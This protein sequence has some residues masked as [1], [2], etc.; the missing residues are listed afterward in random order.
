MKLSMSLVEYW[1]KPYNPVSILRDD[2]RTIASARMFSYDKVINSDYLY[3]GRNKDFFE[4]STS[5]EVLLVHKNSVIST[6]SRDLEEIF[7]AVL[8]A[9]T[10]FQEW[11]QNMLEAFHAA[12]P[13]AHIIDQ[14]KEFFGPIFYATSSLQVT[15]FSPEY[16]KGSVNQ[17]WDDFWDYGTFSTDSFHV[18]KH[19]PFMKR[20]S[21]VWECEVF[22]ERT[23]GENYPW[24]LMI[25]QLNSANVLCGQMVIISDKM[26]QPWQMHLAKYIHTILCMVAGVGRQQGTESLSLANSMFT[27]F[28]MGKN[29]TAMNLQTLSQ[30]QGYKEK[31]L[32][33]ICFVWQE[34]GLKAAGPYYEK[35]IRERFSQ[36]LICSSQD[37]PLNKEMKAPDGFLVC[38][39]L[40]QFSL[41]RKE[42]RI[43]ADHYPYC[44]SARAFLQFFEQMQLSY[45]CSFP[46]EGLRQ[47][48]VQY[49]QA[50]AAWKYGASDYYGCGL[51]ELLDLNGSREQRSYAVNPIIARM[52]E[53]DSLYNSDFYKILKS[54]LRNERNRVKTAEELYVHK[55]TLVYRLEKMEQIFGLNLEDSYEREYL[56]AS[57]RTLEG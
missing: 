56:L 30:I 7:N 16:G 1:L 43:S 48:P 54:Y 18:M 19:S 53:Y 6:N 26:F 40:P 34:N 39:P 9:F 32:F 55:N 11:E 17:N 12:N 15:A 5:E 33:M 21:S 50:M 49:A 27:D 28:L 29:V 46:M 3:I 31:Q 38:I 35:R 24:S 36:I 23:P 14:C 2:D 37:L 41:K 57:I 47:I 10:Y 51:K 4:Q 8:D 42:N 45:A 13:E 52:K 44:G 25:S 22:E 20:F